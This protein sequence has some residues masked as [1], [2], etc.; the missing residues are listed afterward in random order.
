MLV[1]LKHCTVV[2]LLKVRLAEMILILDNSASQE[3][4]SLLLVNA[5]SARAAIKNILSHNEHYKT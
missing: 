2:N 1:M 5:V 3:L 4:L